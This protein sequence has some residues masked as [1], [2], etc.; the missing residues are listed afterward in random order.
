MLVM[1]HRNIVFIFYCGG[2][3]GALSFFSRIRVRCEL[4]R[5]TRYFA[6]NATHLLHAI[7]NTVERADTEN[8]KTE[9]NQ[10]MN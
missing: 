1:V 9:Y 3:G 6:V 10:Q 5:S 4:A 8:K 2:G 7:H